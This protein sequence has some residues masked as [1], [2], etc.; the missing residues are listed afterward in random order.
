MSFLPIIVFCYH[1]NLQK[2]T[3]ADLSLAKRVQHKVYMPLEILAE[4]EER[5]K[6]RRREVETDEDRG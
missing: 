3:R 4:R 2:S 6:K 1:L 5:I